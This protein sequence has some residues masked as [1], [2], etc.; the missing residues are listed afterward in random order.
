LG[1]S[2]LYGVHRRIVQCDVLLDVFQGP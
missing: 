1:C 2:P